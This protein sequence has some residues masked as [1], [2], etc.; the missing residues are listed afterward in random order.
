[1]ANL[2]YE[3]HTK[4]SRWVRCV[5]SVVDMGQRSENSW[6]GDN[7]VRGN[8]RRDFKWYV[9]PRILAVWFGLVRNWNSPGHRQK[10]KEVKVHIKQQAF[11]NGVT[12]ALITVLFILTWIWILI[13]V[14]FFGG[15]LH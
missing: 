7:W 11:D 14:A 10:R 4:K 6:T 8:K 1:M 12:L 9:P 15:R 2:I 5:K 13:A 3:A